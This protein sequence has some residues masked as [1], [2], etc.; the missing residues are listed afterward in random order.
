M[1]FDVGDNC[2][3]RWENTNCW[4]LAQVVE[5]VDNKYTLYFPETSKTRKGYTPNRVRPEQSPSRTRSYFLDKT[6]FDAADEDMPEGTWKVRRLAANGTEYT[7]VR[8]T[9]DS[10]PNNANIVNFDVGYVMRQVTEMMQK[11]REDVTCDN[12]VHSRLRRR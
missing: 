3:G 1:L 7:C 10:G 6:F 9:G 4:Y 8:L 12:V 2:L 5:V 11:R